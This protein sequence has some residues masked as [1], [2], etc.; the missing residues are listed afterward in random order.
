MIRVAV[1]ISALLGGVVFVGLASGL[2]FTLLGLR[3]AVEG[4]AGLMIALIVGWSSEPC[5][6]G[7]ALRDR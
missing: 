4:A 7:I 3:M 1:S 6:S 2:L 5:V